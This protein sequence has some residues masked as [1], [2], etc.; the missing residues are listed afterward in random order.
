MPKATLLVPIVHCAQLVVFVMMFRRQESV[1]HLLAF[2]P[3]DFSP[4][5]AFPLGTPSDAIILDRK[6]V[7]MAPPAEPA[8]TGCLKDDVDTSPS[9]ERSPKVGG[10]I[11]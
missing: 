9:K 3:A 10:S 4:T 8:P 7:T 6:F 2:C 5:C 11:G 1:I